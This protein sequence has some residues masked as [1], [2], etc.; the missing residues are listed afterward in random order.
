[1]VGR[2][3]GEVTPVKPVVA[4]WYTVRW[5]IGTKGGG[6]GVWAGGLECGVGSERVKDDE[7]GRLTCAVDD[8][9]KDDLSVGGF[10][11]GPCERVW[12]IH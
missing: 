7:E 11:G 3:M 6:P 5:A 10:D 4:C 9:D 12:G 2:V 8:D 1:M